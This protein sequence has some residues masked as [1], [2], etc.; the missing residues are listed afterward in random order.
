MTSNCKR[1]SSTT[2][3]L[4]PPIQPPPSPS[5]LPQTAPLSSVQVT[6]ALNSVLAKINSVINQIDRRKR[7]T[8]ISCS[9]FILKIYQLLRSIE[10]SQSNWSSLVGEILFTEVEQCDS[11]ELNLLKD[12]EADI[13]N[14]KSQFTTTINSS[15]YSLSS[16]SSST[17]TTTITTTT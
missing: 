12:V 8:K 11:R 6:S 13:E 9:T 5:P 16:T 15:T 7:S 4:Q 10:R 2:T 17:T 3:T 14:L 1:P